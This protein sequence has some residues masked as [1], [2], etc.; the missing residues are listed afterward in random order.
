MIMDEAH[1]FKYSVH[2][3]ADKMYYDLRDTYWWLG[4]KRYIATYV[5]KCL[6][7]SK[8]KAEH[9]RPSGLLQQPEIPEW[10]WDKITMD[11]IT[12]LPRSKSGHD[13][14]W[15]IVDRLTKSAHFLAIREDYSTEKLAKIYIDEIVARHGVPVSIISDRDGR[16]TSR[17]WQTVQKALGTRLDMST[18]YHPQ[19]DGKSERTFQT[20]ED[21]LRAC[22]IDFDGSWDVHLPLAEFSYNNSYHSSIRC[23]PFEALYGRKCR[24]PILWAEIGESSL[25]GPELVQ[26]TTDK[27]VLI[28]EKLKAVRD[29]QKSYVD[30]R[31]KPLEFEVGD[32]VMLKVSPW[33]GVIRFGK[34]GKLAP[35][36]VG[37]FEILERIGLSEIKIDKTL[38]FVE[39][40]VEIMDR[41]VKSLNRSKIALVKKIDLAESNYSTWSYF[42][43]GHCSNFGVLKHIEGSSTQSS[44]STPP[45]DDWI[46]ADSI[47]KSWIFLTLSSTLRKRLTKANPKTAKDAW[48][49]IEAIFQ[50]N[51][52]TR[53]VAL[54]GEIRMIQ[55][56]DQTADEYFSNIDSIVT[57]LNDLGSDVSQDDVVTYAINGLSDKYGSLAQ[58]IAHKE[59]FPDLFIVRLMVSTE[60]MRIRNKFSLPMSSTRSN[61][62]QNN[63]RTNTS[64]MHTGIGFGNRGLDLAAQQQLLSLLQAQNT[65]LAQYGLSTISIPR[66]PIGFN[67]SGQR[68]VPAQPSAQQQLM[69]HGLTP[70]QQA[71]FTNDPANANWHMDTGASSH[72]NSSAHN[73]STIFNSRMYPSVLVGDGKSI[74]VTNTGHS[75]LPT[76]YRPLHLNNVLVTPNI[77]KNLIYVRQFVRENKCTIEFDEFGFSVKDFRTRGGGCR[78]LCV[79]FSL[80]CDRNGE[81]LPRST[82]PSYLKLFWLVQQTWHND[83]RS[84]W[85]GTVEGSDTAYLLLYVDD[86]VLTASSIALLQRIIASLHA[87]FFMTDLGPLNYF[88]G[89]SV[90]RNTSGM[91]LSQQKYATK[92]LERDTVTTM[93]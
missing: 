31:R 54:K 53:V 73:L 40:L 35:R 18:A 66:T 15:V 63:T 30:N 80:R 8:V 27:V 86:I 76:P 43:K 4:M 55:M 39:E 77:V 92:V 32:Q 81:S 10:K 6:T 19:T 58:I 9:Q 71:L 48:D 49:T 52:R 37:P 34:K 20:L 75:T 84:S 91:F 64:N 29:R 61:S 59:P 12:K 79:K 41:E 45:T 47:V 25:I 22:V 93:A 2:P 70:N 50:D 16:F 23:A 78:V 62:S 26:E 68:I 33:K 69:T 51:K 7:C 90:T 17:C 1:K 87:E 21:M 13:T 14:I 67:N 56:G 72:L 28:K 74:P 24:S 85:K 46:T 36:Y 3:G 60:E 5:S 83:L 88:L 44:T 82:S 65:L 11:F 42:F 89:V 57:L 38:R